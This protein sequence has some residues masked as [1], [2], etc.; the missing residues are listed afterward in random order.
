MYLACGPWSAVSRVCRPGPSTSVSAASTR[1]TSRWSGTTSTAPRP[2]STAARAASARSTGQSR[3]AGEGTVR[4]EAVG[5]PAE[6]TWDRKAAPTAYEDH[7]CAGRSG[8]GAGSGGSRASA[9]SAVA[10]RGGTARRRT[11]PSDPAY[12]PATVRASASTAGVSTGSGE[13]T[14]RSGLRRPTCSASARRSTTKPSRSCPAKRTLTRTPGRAVSAIDAGTVYSNGRSRWASPVS[15]WTRA[16]G[17]SSEVGSSPARRRGRRTAA[18]G[19]SSASC[20]P[21][22]PCSTSLTAPK[23][24]EPTDPV[25]G[26]WARAVDDGAAQ[27]WTARW[28]ASTR[29]VRS[30]VKGLSTPSAVVRPKW[31]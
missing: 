18:R 25:R 16:T 28:S 27:P 14:L 9:F 22:S 8:I 5:A 1:T 2:P 30:H 11:S 20:S 19:V 6:V 10:C 23:L 21:S 26:R 17:R 15:T 4:R 24:A 3:A 7:A 13:T 12:R 29:S 31:P